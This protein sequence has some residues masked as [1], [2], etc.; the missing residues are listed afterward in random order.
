M[1]HPNLVSIFG[2]WSVN[3]EGA[4]VNDVSMS[5]GGFSPAT[6]ATAVF[7]AAKVES[8]TRLVIAMQL[9]GVSLFIRLQQ[10]QAEGKKGIPREELLGYMRDAARGI[11]YLNEPIHDLGD[12]AVSIVH[13]NIKPQNLLLVGGGVQV[14]DYSLVRTGGRVAEDGHGRQLHAG[15]RG[16]RAARQ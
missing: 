10:C 3:R 2:I 11:D 16:P 14:C 9:G 8:A 15:L 1:V 5:S 4:V 7:D 6:A 12:G 13:G